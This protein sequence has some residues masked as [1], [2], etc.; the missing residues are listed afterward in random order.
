MKKNLFFLLLMG[1]T[2]VSCSKDVPQNEPKILPA[3]STLALDLAGDIL[4]EAPSG[5]EKAL[6]FYVANNKVQATLKGKTK[7]KVKTYLYSNGNLVWSA[8]ADWKVI[9]NGAGLRYEG[10]ITTSAPL[11]VGQVK[12][13]AIL[14]SDYSPLSA[15]T[16]S[17]AY[18]VK[19]IA[20]GNDN[21]TSIDVPYAMQ[22][23]ITIKDD[24]N[25]SNV[26]SAATNKV[27]KPYGN[28][29]RFRMQNT[30]NGEVKVNSLSI[31]L[32][33]T[34]YTLKPNELSQGTKRES[35][36]A[37]YSRRSIPLQNPVVIP[38]NSTSDKN[39]VVWV[40]ELT[41][42]PSVTLV[43]EGPTL[44]GYYAVYEPKKTSYTPGKQYTAL[45]KI[46]DIKNPLWYF[47]IGNASAQQFT[48]DQ[49]LRYT[50]PSGYKI[51][52][53]AQW[54]SVFPGEDA[55][56]DP[57]KKSTI[58]SRSDL[59]F[60]PG[61]I[62]MEAGWSGYIQVGNSY[63]NGL[64][65]EMMIPMLA[66][67]ANW[68]PS[69]GYTSYSMLYLQ[70]EGIMFTP[71]GDNNPRAAFR[72][73]WSPGPFG[74]GNYGKMIV[75]CKLLPPRASSDIREVEDLIDNTKM[76]WGGQNVET[77]EFQVERVRKGEYK[78]GYWVID[79]KGYA[80]G[81]DLIGGVGFAGPVGGDSDSKYYLRVYR[82]DL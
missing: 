33:N 21:T 75:T 47:N 57:T 28:I 18:S 31:S 7:A 56:I 70:K 4:S 50:P 2:F 64:R 80:D 77:R 25:I 32:P 37:P 58:G 71:R 44:I 29:L 82:T 17:T 73:S 48:K 67:T 68:D 8:D 1:L 59:R 43:C 42:S 79:P 81:T 74:S 36:Y 23:D 41:D 54:W 72:Y 66:E 10:E 24:G 34:S 14:A 20:T 11:Q 6:D 30:T 69:I 16:A 60:P 61:Y 38:A 51:P 12:L 22:S 76:N 78:G 53:P 3:G 39:L 19:A 35:S 49:L 45:L 62:V 9:N 52:S 46:R 5:E 63:Q 55:R 26:K 65:R 40:G 27:F 15:P 13:V